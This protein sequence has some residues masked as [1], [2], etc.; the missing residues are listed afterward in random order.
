MTAPWKD[1]TWACKEVKQLPKIW[2]GP[3][4]GLNPGLSL[5]TCPR[6]SQPDMPPL[7][8]SRLPSVEQAGGWDAGREALPPSTACNIDEIC[9]LRVK[10][11]CVPN[12]VPGL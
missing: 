7:P 1:E 8:G 6:S 5:H 12:A 2:L 3:K 4:R 9:G 10:S 11:F